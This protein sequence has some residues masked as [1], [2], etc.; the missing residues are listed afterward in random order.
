MWRLG[1]DDHPGVE[2]QPGVN[3]KHHLTA[4]ADV[5]AIVGDP[6]TP[7][8]AMIDQPYR[9]HCHPKHAH[10]T[11]KKRRREALS[12]ETRGTEG[13]GARPISR[14]AGATGKDADLN[15]IMGMK[16]GC[17]QGSTRVLRTTFP[18]RRWCATPVFSGK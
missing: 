10:L 3:I 9:N 5:G 8:R 15:L 18:A 7:C 4:L 16:S 1:I 17:P 2:Q 14:L 12:A 6:A 13:D 11:D